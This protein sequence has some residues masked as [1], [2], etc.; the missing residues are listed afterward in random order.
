[1]VMVPTLL[2][3]RVAVKVCLPAAVYT[4]RPDV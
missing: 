3:G 1:M 2:R 4:L